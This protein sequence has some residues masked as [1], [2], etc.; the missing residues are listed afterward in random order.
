M[1]IDHNEL[2]PYERSFYT[3]LDTDGEVIF[4][5]LA[6]LQTSLFSGCRSWVRAYCRLRHQYHKW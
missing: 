2:R 6:R 3:T 1:K 4:G 5:R